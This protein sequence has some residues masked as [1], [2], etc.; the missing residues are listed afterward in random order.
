MKK[1]QIVPLA[2]IIGSFSVSFASEEYQSS[3]KPLSVEATPARILGKIADGTPPPPEPP[4]PKFIIPAKDVLESKSIQ[5]G[6]RT[7]TVRKIDPITLPPPKEPAA[8]IDFTDPAVQERIAKFRT[9]NKGN[10]RSLLVSATVYR[11]N[12]SPPRSLVR[13]WPQAQGQPV[14]VWSSADFSLLSGFSTFVGP[15]G[16]TNSLML[17]WSVTN[18]DNQ[19]AFH[20]KFASRFKAPEIPLFPPGKAT[21]MVTAGEATPETLAALQSLHDLYNNEF[22]RLKAAFEGRERAQRLQEA[23]LKANPPKPKDVVFSY[24]NMVPTT[25]SNQKGSTR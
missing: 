17:M 14:T 19:T 18:L 3:A 20:A 25:E 21:F 2:V 5:Q 24:W 12:E 10:Y 8:Q 23:E 1:I 7:I 22:H 11:F 9:K 15:S 4:K 6:G 13:V 16:E